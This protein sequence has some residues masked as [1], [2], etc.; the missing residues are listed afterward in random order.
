MKIKSIADLPWY[1][2]YYT[3]DIIHQRNLLMQ[4]FKTMICTCTCIVV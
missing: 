2:E 1:Q 4:W 3:F